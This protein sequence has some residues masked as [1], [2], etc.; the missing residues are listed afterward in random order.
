MTARLDALLLWTPR[1]LGVLVCLFLSLFAL[2]AFEEGT[3]FM[4]ALPGFLIHLVPTAVLLGVVALS[5]RREWI[6]GV[7]FVGL[8]GGYAYFARR[9]V[10]WIL[11][12]SGPLLV[13]GTL[14]VYSWVHRR[15]QRRGAR[16]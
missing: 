15:R 4:Q 6:G 13:V 16:T 10:A 11:T 14:F 8:A 1:V 5:W 12:I 7:V 9:H 2:D 3:P